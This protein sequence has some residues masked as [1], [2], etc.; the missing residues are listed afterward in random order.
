MRKGR[1]GRSG[2]PQGHMH[3]VVRNEL[4]C[5][6]LKSVSRH[7][8]TTK[9]CKSPGWN[10]VASG[11]ELGW[12]LLSNVRLGR[13][14]E[15]KDEAGGQRSELTHAYDGICRHCSTG[16]RPLDHTPESNSKLR[17]MRKTGRRIGN[18]S[19]KYCQPSFA[20]CR[21]VHPPTAAGFSPTYKRR[22]KPRKSR[23]PRRTMARSGASTGLLARSPPS[24]ENCWYNHGPPSTLDD[25]KLRCG[26]TQALEASLDLT[27]FTLT[28]SHHRDP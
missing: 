14:P 23:R 18:Q 19:R 21:C 5:Y 25:D 10:R 12:L 24:K 13:R 9:V 17:G 3:I 4:S 7:L 8:D 16:E 28:H 27:E 11:A 2:T 1:R 22:G 15:Q 26:S 20:S 6:R